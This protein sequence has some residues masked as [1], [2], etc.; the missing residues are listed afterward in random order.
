MGLCGNA[1]AFASWGMNLNKKY[2]EARE[3]GNEKR[4]ERERESIFKA[5]RR[6]A[7]LN[8]TPVVNVNAARRSTSRAEESEKVR[9]SQTVSTILTQLS[10]AYSFWK[11]VSARFS[12]RNKKFFFRFRVKFRWKNPRWDDRFDPDLRLRYRPLSTGII[13]IR[14]EY[15]LFPFFEFL[16][17]FK[18]FPFW[19]VSGKISIQSI[20]I[21]HILYPPRGSDRPTRVLTDPVR[22]KTISLLKVT[23]QT[24]Q[25]ISMIRLFHNFC[26]STQWKETTLEF[27]N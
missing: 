8:K 2:E 11:R 24:G 6:L 12:G 4:R 18:A 21:F 10:N 20:I 19:Y 5:A 22:S 17:L 25:R 9:R 16:S 27:R 14:F 13:E 15:F 1:D 7:S 3:T 23:G 26:N